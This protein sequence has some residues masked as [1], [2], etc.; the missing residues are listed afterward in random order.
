MIKAINMS[1]LKNYEMNS[2]YRVG[3]K[4]GFS[5]QDVLEF[6][7]ST[8]EACEIIPPKGISLDTLRIAYQNSIKRYGNNQVHLR[9][10]GNKIFMVKQPSKKR[11]HRAKT[12]IQTPQASMQVSNP[13]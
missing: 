7:H 9:S 11:N 13:S 1:E 6:L 5:S 2:N 12:S 8:G 10:F 3:R 4:P